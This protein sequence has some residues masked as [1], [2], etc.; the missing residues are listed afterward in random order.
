VVMSGGRIVFDTPAASAD[1]QQLG[2]HMGGH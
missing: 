1:R 2:H